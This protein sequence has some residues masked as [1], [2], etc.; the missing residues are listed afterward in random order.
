VDVTST[1]LDGLL[2]L[3]FVSA[4]VVTV[5]G[6]TPDS[7]TG[8]G[9]APDV[10]TTLATTT[11]TVDYTLGPPAGGA[12][13][14]MAVE[15]DRLDR[16]AHGTLAELLARAAV[17]RL[18]VDGRRLSNARAGFADGVGDAVAA[19]VRANHTRVTATWRPYPGSSVRGR[20]AVGARPPPD[21]PVHVAALTTPSGFPRRRAAARAA[22][23]ERGIDGVADAVA[24]GIVSG[25]F[26]ATRTRLAATGPRSALVRRRYRRAARL[27]GVRRRTGPPDGRVDAANDRLAAALSRH[28]RRDIRESSA[29][30][31]RAAAGVDLGVVRITVRTWP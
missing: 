27:F 6:T 10:A 19:A 18:T 30:D 11:A 9:R 5:T 25:L 1:V 2:C 17:G 8:E 31:R 24:D 29:S 7:P 23:E 21:V 12:E 28:V 26:P 3:L 15:R 14:A 13:R 16:T 4:A 22:A 20:I